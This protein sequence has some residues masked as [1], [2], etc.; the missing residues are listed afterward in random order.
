[1]NETP[2]ILASRLNFDVVLYRGHTR[3][4]MML[5]GLISLSMTVLLLGI[6][7]KLLLGMFLIG[8]GLSFPVSISVGWLLAVVFQK[9][10]EGKPRGYVKQQFLLWLH[11]QGIRKSPFVNYSGLWNLKRLFH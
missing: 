11:R 10:K 3:K 4:E 2:D 5:L 8:L 7:T 9:L 6:I 1:M